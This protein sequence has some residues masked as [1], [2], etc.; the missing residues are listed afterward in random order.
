MEMIAI[1][2]PINKIC[3]N[4]FKDQKL[5]HTHTH[6]QKEKSKVKE[7]QSQSSRFRYNYIIYE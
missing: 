6:T 1:K 2:L 5:E 7:N 4:R 3:T